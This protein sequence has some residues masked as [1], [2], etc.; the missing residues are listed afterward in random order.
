LILGRG[1]QGGFRMEL[2]Y[3][4]KPLAG[5]ILEEDYLVVSPEYS[6]VEVY[7]NKKIIYA[8]GGKA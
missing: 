7:G 6:V 3:S 8:T 4:K 2:S 5:T 1:I